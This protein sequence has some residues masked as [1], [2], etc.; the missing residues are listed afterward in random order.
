MKQPDANQLIPMVQKELIFIQNLKQSLE[1]KQKEIERDQFLLLKKLD[2]IKKKEEFLLEK[3]TKIDYEVEL[4]KRELSE[5]TQ[6][7]YQLL[8]CL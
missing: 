1:L 5:K 8:A 4:K 7:V 2:Q 6:A 3:E